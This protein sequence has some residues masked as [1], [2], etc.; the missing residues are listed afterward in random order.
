VTFCQNIRYELV[1]ITQ[2]ADRF[3]SISNS[4]EIMLRLRPVLTQWMNRLPL[5]LRITGRSCSSSVQSVGWDVQPAILENRL[6][7]PEDVGRDS[8]IQNHR[9]IGTLTL[10]SESTLNA[11]TVEMGREFQSLVSTVAHD[12]TTGQQQ[13][14]AVVLVG[15]GDT[16]FSAGGDL[17]WL[18]SLRENTVHANADLMLQFYK[19]FLCIRSIP[20]PVIAALHGPAMGAGAGLALACDLR[21][22]APH[23]KLLGLHF[24][25]LG[26][27]TG[28]GSSHYLPQVLAA[29]SGMVNEI[30][31][32]G[33]IL[34]GDECYRLGLVNRLADDAKQAATDLAVAIA[35]DPHPVAV[36]TLVQTLRQQQDQG[37]EQ[38]LQREA[39]AQAICYSRAD[40]GEGIEAIAAKRSPSF[41]PYHA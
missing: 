10:Q 29:G 5:V 1:W 25:R 41:D 39:M 7:K 18:R 33:R 3:D 12:I 24:S 37:L 35:L 19:S 14:D 27:H 20:V 4:T 17:S 36:R 40:W 22:A 16:A 8:N 11:L 28:M 23:P 2:E 26:I 15:A 13:V 31:L 9:F 6:H 30:L 32:M 38:A 21:T 34:S